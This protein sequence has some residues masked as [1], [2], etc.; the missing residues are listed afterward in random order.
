[1]QVIVAT[2]HVGE[3]FIDRLR[4]KFPQIEFL[5]LM[6]QNT[7]PE[8]FIMAEIFF[9]W[10]DAHQFLSLKNLKWIACPGMGID[11][12]VKY[13]EI[14]NSKVIITNSPGTHVNAMADYAIGMMISLSHKFAENY[15]DQQSK[16]WDT[17][18]YNSKIVELSG[19][20]L[21]IYGF[22]EIGKAIAKRAQGFDMEI[23][24]LDAEDKEIPDYVKSLLLND[25]LDELC[26]KSDYLV[27]T[28]PITENTRNSI[29]NEQIL[30]MKKGTFIIIVSRGG[31]V[32][33]DALSKNLISGHLGGAA[34]DAT[35]IEPLPIDS[36]LWNIENLLISP[37]VS[38]L[39]PELYERRRLIFEEN[40]FRYINNKELNFVCDKKS[41]S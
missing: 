37:H 3:S 18:K 5:N 23:I 15:I 25:Q 20:T 21:G 7:I 39:S 26:K 4:N 19:K 41:F 1:M 17:E 27:V 31:L 14:L 38:A 8:E 40:L 11:K 16:I 33:E 13:E 28:A 12:I 2:D 34:I 29:N 24:A 36:N 9:G 10:P 6:D 22:G 32:N 35:D 30:Y